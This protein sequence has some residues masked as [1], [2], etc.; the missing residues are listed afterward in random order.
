LSTL[1]A[2]RSC[3]EPGGYVRLMK[4]R[5]AGVTNGPLTSVGSVGRRPF[6][7]PGSAALIG[8]L[9]LERTHEPRLGEEVAEQLGEAAVVHQAVAAA[10]DGQA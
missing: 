9:R 5:S 2:R 8:E 7:G 1:M 10:H 6:R 3:V 4:S